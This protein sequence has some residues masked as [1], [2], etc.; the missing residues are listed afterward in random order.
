MAFEESKRCFTNGTGGHKRRIHL[1]FKRDP[2]GEEGRR[3]WYYV[4]RTRAGRE[5]FLTLF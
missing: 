3:R 1:I 4:F 5:V 2:A